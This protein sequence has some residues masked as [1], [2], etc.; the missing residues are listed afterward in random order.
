M[1]DTLPDL[2]SLRLLTLVAELGSLGRAAE[3]MRISQPAASKRLSM[4]ERRLGVLLVER[5]TRGSALTTEGR[6]VCHWSEQVLAE[7]A[8]LM[9]GVAALRAEGSR[10]LRVASSMTLAES[11]LPAWVAELQ[12]QSP[13]VQ[14]S[15]KV[16]NSEQVAT[17]A[18]RH[19]ISIGFV[20]GPT[21]P[22][23]LS[24]RT[25]ATDRLVVVVT[26]T[27]PWARRR[28]PVRLA[29]LAATPLIVREPGSGTRETLER[30]FAGAGLRPV[31]PLIVLDVNAAVRS[32]AAASIGPAV[33]SA[34]TVEDDLALGHLVEIRLADAEL[35]RK[36]RAVWPKTRPLPPAAET[37][38]RIARSP[39]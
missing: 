34:A 11:F 20:E 36:L 1:S 5:D 33:L 23:G 39:R 21:V 24:S 27:H 4:L 7:A 17:L 25:V 19:E 30:V 29:E 16:T 10:D 26:R 28:R 2:D 12:R 6:A 35:R 9:A 22:H 31:E 32:A 38:L 8:N 13:G 37:L 14:L 18:A 3:R 15:L